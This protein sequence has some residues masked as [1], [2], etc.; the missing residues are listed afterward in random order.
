MLNFVEN[1]LENERGPMNDQDLTKTDYDHDPDRSL[2][3][4]EG[5]SHFLTN[6]LQNLASCQT[7]L[8]H[9]ECWTVFQFLRS[10]KE[11]PTARNEICN[12]I[13]ITSNPP[14]DSQ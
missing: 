4:I 12:N 10:A 3:L 5:L 11:R 8:R 2:V 1:L 14:F 7:S 9:E 6:F 13:Y